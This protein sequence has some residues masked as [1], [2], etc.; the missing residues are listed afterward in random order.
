ME[1]DN[2]QYHSS[3]KSPR[4]IVLGLINKFGRDARNKKVYYPLE[5]EIIFR[6]ALNTLNNLPHAKA[7]LELNNWK[8][9][10]QIQFIE[11]PESFDIILHQRPDQDSLPKQ[12]IRNISKEEINLV[13]GAINISES[14]INKKTKEVYYETPE[15]AKNF[16]FLTGMKDNK[17]GHPLFD[18][19]GIFLWENYFGDR[20]LHT[21]L[22]LCL[23]ILDHYN[24][25]KYRGGRSV[26]LNKGFKFQLNLQNK[27]K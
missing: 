7:T 3:A 26:V 21:N 5:L 25:T 6:E 8:R 13:I 23:R 24:I 22:N 9:K 19:D 17:N 27:Y 11:K 1:K 12:S 16:T 15:I 18:K 2:S 14:K 4:G 20:F 10:D